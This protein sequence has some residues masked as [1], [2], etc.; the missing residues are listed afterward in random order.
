MFEDFEA[1]GTVAEALAVLAD[2]PGRLVVAGGTDVLPAL[3]SGR[4]RPG[5]VLSLSRCLDLD[6]AGRTEN[7]GLWLGAVL[8]CARAQRLAGVLPALAAAA[9]AVGPPGVRNAATVGG[10]LASAAGGDLLALLMAAGGRVRLEASIGHRD[11]TVAEFLAPLAAGGTDP[12]LRSQ[13]LLAGVLIEP[14]PAVLRFARIADPVTGR[15]LVALSLALDLE[16]RTF[17]VAVQGE[18]RVPRRVS[19]AEQLI[20][21]EL[22]RPAGS[23]TVAEFARLVGT[24]AG[25][26]PYRRRVATVL[27]ARLLTQAQAA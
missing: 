12:Y 3:R 18:S 1:P 14:V 7:G 9:G 21:A 8:T 20:R 11:C 2:D 25:S 26:D 23:S 24:A 15:A 4:L 17:A 16:A 27:A 6:G 13:E 5:R 10:N 19:E 22:P